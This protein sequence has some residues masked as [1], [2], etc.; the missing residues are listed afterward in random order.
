MNRAM[1]SM[2]FFTCS[3]Q[4]QALSRCWWN[5]CPNRTF[6]YSARLRKG[7]CGGG[8]FSLLPQVRLLGETSLANSPWYIAM[9]YPWFSF[10]TEG[11]SKCASALFLLIINPLTQ[12]AR[13]AMKKN[14]K[15][16]NS[17]SWRFVLIFRAVLLLMP[18]KIAPCEEG[19]IK[20]RDILCHNGWRF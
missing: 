1:L 9:L 20:K 18:L 6:P 2:L 19:F 13:E 11:G 14:G 12:Y 3:A 15:F 4:H 8:L 10:S 17:T 5:K 7:R 16:A